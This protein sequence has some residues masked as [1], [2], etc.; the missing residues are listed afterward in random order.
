MYYQLNCVFKKEAT[1]CDIMLQC[2]GWL[3]ECCYVNYECPES[4]PGYCFEVFKVSRE[5][6]R[7]LLGGCS[8]G[9]V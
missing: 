2:H 5:V 4:L 6:A 7:V 9:Q 3:P 8:L 1:E